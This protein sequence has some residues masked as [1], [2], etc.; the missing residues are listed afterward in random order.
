[1]PIFQAFDADGGLFILAFIKVILAFIPVVL[2]CLRCLCCDREN[3][4]ASEVWVIYGQTL[5]I[6]VCKSRLPVGD[7]D[8]NADNT[9]IK[10]YS[11]ALKL[12]SVSQKR[13]SAVSNWPSHL[14]WHIH[15]CWGL[16]SILKMKHKWTWTKGD[17][18]WGVKSYSREWRYV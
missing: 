11:R 9:I 18:P 16:F 10:Q 15:F 8:H 7:W 6:Y 2:S 17:R 1:M 14:C 13:P 12:E 5:P 4:S 3:S